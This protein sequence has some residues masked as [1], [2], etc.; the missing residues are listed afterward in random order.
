MP[1]ERKRVIAFM[2]LIAEDPNF[3]KSLAKDIFRFGNPSLLDKTKTRQYYE[4]FMGELGR[5]DSKARAIYFDKL[6]EMGYNAVRDDLDS[7]VLGRHPII[8]LDAANTTVVDGAKRVSALT[9]ILEIF[10][11]NP[12]DITADVRGR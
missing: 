11:I 7:G 1:S 2:G 5:E 6:R 10:K 4:L 12:K 9:E 3:R 8:L